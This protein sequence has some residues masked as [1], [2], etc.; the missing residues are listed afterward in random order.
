MAVSSTNSRSNW[1]EEWWASP[2]IIVLSQKGR[3]PNSPHYPKSAGDWVLFVVHPKK[4]TCTLLT[5]SPSRLLLPPPFFFLPRSPPSPHLLNIAM[6]AR[7]RQSRHHGK[8]HSTEKQ[9]RLVKRW[10][11]RTPPRR[12]GLRVVCF[13]GAGCSDSIYTLSRIA[14]RVAHNPLL[15]WEQDGGTPTISCVSLLC[16][17]QKDQF[18]KRPAT[19]PPPLNTHSQNRTGYPCIFFSPPLV[20]THLSLSIPL[21]LSCGHQKMT[22]KFWGSN[23]LAV[24]SS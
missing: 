13:H 8:E 1:M 2:A 16:A 6:S 15:A 9:D 18:A 22:C 10:L 7:K 11:P 3:C 21:S 12:C 14:G 5:L 17:K 4:N 19:L 24:S 20:A 23:F